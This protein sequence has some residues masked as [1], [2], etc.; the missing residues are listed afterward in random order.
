MKAIILADNDNRALRP[1]NSRKP[2]ALIRINGISLLEHQIR[3]YLNAGI[4]EAS[5]TV[6]SGY[7]HNADERY[8]ARA[9]PSLNILS[10]GDYHLKSAACSLH[11][12]L[13]RAEFEGADL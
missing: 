13:Q 11:L 2:G 12:V 6:V 8:L 7:R 10:S 9:H 4:A 5:I 3:G 1:L